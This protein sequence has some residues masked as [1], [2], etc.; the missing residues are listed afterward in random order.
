M[1]GCTQ[2][3][4]A[5][6]RAVVRRRRRLLCPIAAAAVAGPTTAWAALGKLR[7]EEALYGVGSVLR[8]FCS[9]LRDV[10]QVFT[11]P[12]CCVGEV[13]NSHRPSSGR[14]P[15]SRRRV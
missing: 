13:V 15:R 6:Q 11:Q 1:R 8:E 5:L 3:D 4:G 14:V 7:L 10:V 9:R 2:T 12:R